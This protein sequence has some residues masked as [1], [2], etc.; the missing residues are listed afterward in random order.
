MNIYYAASIAGGRAYLGAYRLMVKFIQDQGHRV[1]TEHIIAE[2]VLEQESRLTPS[3]IYRRDVAWLADCDAMIAEISNPS[4]GVG[5]EIG[6]A[7]DLGKRILCLHKEG[8]FISR[9]IIGNDRAGLNIAAYA[10]D[11][12]W[13][14]QIAYFLSAGA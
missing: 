13:Q 3:E 11:E 8:L 1:L 9:M 6:Y 10:S 2:D 5:Y 12:E 4:L 14:Q 7:L